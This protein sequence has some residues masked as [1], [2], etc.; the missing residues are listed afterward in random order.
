M[1]GPAYSQTCRVAHHHIVCI[2]VNRCVMLQHIPYNI[3]EGALPGELHSGVDLGQVAKR[4]GSP[5]REV[6][7]AAEEGVKSP[8]EQ[9]AEHLV[10]ERKASKDAC[11]Q[12][13]WQRE[14]ARLRCLARWLLAS[15]FLHVEVAVYNR[16]KSDKSGQKLHRR[17][18]LDNPLF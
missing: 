5:D 2:T 4:D 17:E 11:Q 1:K 10:F 16:H 9:L 13:I 3:A 7:R 8:G 18:K 6:S 14:Y 15:A 12:L